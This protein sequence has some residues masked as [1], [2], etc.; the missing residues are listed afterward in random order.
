MG[1][2]IKEVVIIYYRLRLKRRQF[3]ES[4]DWQE[5]WNAHHFVIL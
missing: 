4:I 5:R 3:C 1:L 2:G